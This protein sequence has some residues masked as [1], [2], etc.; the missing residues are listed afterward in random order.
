MM[1]DIVKPEHFACNQVSFITFN[2]DRVFEHLLFQGLRN[3]FTT[4]HLEEINRILSSIQVFHVY[5]CIDE[6]P[7]KKGEYKYG[8]S[9]TLQYLD[10]ARKRIQIVGE[11]AKNWS[12]MEP[13]VLR[14]LFDWAKK[15][16]FLGFG[17]DRENLEILR[18]PERFKTTQ[19]HPKFY[20]TGLGLLPEQIHSIENRLGE[21]YTIVEACDCT[22][23]LM[24]HLVQNY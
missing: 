5:G 1:V 15:I 12:L 16:F 3:T 17:Y 9:Y 14:L 22:K 13:P 19:Q 24:K 8:D 11:T 7:W 20:G 21:T 4:V 18:I 23:L 6:L 10:E 2:Y